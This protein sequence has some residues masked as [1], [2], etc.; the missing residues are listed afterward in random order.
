M[1]EVTREKTITEV[2]YY[3]A[4]DGMHF[5]S[6]EE[7]ERYEKSAEMVLFKELE[8]YHK[9][10]MTEYDLYN[11]VGSEEYD[12]DIYYIPDADTLHKLNIYRSIL[13]RSAKLIED[14]YISKTILLSWDYDRQYSYCEGTIDDVLT[15]IRN[16]Y[17]KA[18]EPKEEEKEN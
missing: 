18:I 7:C 15:K 2:A 12:V 3:E 5:Q 14:E 9:G 1:K 6:K 4:I 16:A 13:D 10:K 17:N 8:P 11:G